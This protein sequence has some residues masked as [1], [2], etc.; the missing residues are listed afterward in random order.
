[1]D[2]GREVL[3]SKSYLRNRSTATDTKQPTDPQQT[4]ATNRQRNVKETD[5]PC[6]VL[7]R[8][9]SKLAIFGIFFDS[10]FQNSGSTLL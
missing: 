10:D 6:H 7:R 8:P 1:M 9:L 4:T 5:L 3:S 2:K